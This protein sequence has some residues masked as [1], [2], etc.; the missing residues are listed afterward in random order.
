MDTTTIN[1]KIGARIQHLRRE[2]GYTQQVFSEKIGVS[3]NYLS[4]IERGISFPKSDK[5]VAICNT[6]DCSADDLFCD[7]IP[8]S[9]ATRADRLNAMLESLPL[10]EKEKAFAILEAFLGKQS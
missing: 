3:N 9:A 6:L 10:Q 2:K 7:V 8:R 5:L 4:D 1:R